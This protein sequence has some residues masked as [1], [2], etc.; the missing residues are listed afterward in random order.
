[1]MN[2]NLISHRN[3]KMSTYKFNFTVV[4]SGGDLDDAF[5]NAI[6]NFCADPGNAID[7]EVIYVA[8]DSVNEEINVDTKSIN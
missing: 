1:M 5:Q 6:D 3:R 8:V 4:G 2:M 7:G